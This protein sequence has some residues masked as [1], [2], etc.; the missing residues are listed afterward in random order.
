MKVECCLDLVFKFILIGAVDANWSRTGL[1]KFE[2]YFDF[3]MVEFDTFGLLI[4]I[5]SLTILL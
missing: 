3:N 1:L 5:K 2:S 4:P